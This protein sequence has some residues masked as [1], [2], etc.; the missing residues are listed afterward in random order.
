MHV[1]A[2]G[3]GAA[4]IALFAALLVLT[5]AWL[6]WVLRVPVRALAAVLAWQGLMGGLA[7]A[8]YFTRYDQPGRVLPT[9]GASVAAAVWLAS[10]PWGTAVGRWLAA[11]PPWA[12]LALQTFRLPLELLLYSLFVHGVIGAQMTFVGHNVDIVVG[13]SAPLLAVLVGMV[14]RP[15][16][17]PWVRHLAIAWNLLGLLLLLNIVVIAVLSIPFAFQVFTAGPAN[18][19]VAGLPFVWLPTLLVPLALLAHLVSLRL[20]LQRGRPGFPLCKESFR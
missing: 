5:L 8:G 4:H 10:R 3:P 1:E 15:G 18:R 13:L 7:L 11:S 14:G 6:R 9:V 2:V 20:L 17:R 16:A 19:I 12:W